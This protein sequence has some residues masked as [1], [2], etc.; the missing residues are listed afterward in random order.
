LTIPSDFT[1][2]TTPSSGYRVRLLNS[3][4]AIPAREVD[5]MGGEIVITVVNFRNKTNIKTV[6]WVEPLSL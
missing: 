2:Q 4:V 1:A 6:M 5:C 3:D